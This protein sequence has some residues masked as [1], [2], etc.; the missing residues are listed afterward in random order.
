MLVVGVHGIQAVH[1]V[2]FFL[3]GSGIAQSEQG[4]KLF[5]ALLCLFTFH[6]LRL[7]DDQNG[8]CFGNDVD[9]L[10]A[11]EGVQ[12]FVN[13]SLVF[14]GIERLHIDDHDI[15]GTV[16]GKAVHLGEPV[17]GVDKKADFLAVFPGKVFLGGLK[18]FVD[19]FPD[20][21]R[22]HHDDE[23]APAVAL[24]QLVHGL[25][26][27]IGFSGAGFHLNGQIDAR[28]CQS[29][30]G[31]ETITPLDCLQVFQDMG[32]GQLRYQGMIAEAVVAHIQICL[33]I[34]HIAQVQAIGGG[35]VRLAV[36]H[37][38]DC[39]GS[40]CLEGLMFELEFHQ[41][42]FTFVSGER[43][44]KISVTLILSASVAK[45]LS[46]NT[47]R[48]GCCFAICST[49]AVGTRSLKQAMRAPLSTLCTVQ[50]STVSAVW[51]RLIS[52]PQSSRQ[53]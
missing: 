1:H 15:D 26:V 9:G 4:A 19:A 17:R 51:G 31:F 28:P 20:S 41:I 45:A 42:T 10:A 6:A 33:D 22:R 37:I 8:I 7:I 48:R 53:A 43:F 21:N 5:Q 13:D 32:V 39:R 36:E 24:I 50:P 27:C 44:L 40:L 25:D 52:T 16:R 49:T 35:T 38:T 18:G 47:A 30:R 3:V 2:I 11:A 34:G 12:L 46:R 23:L 14:A 29:F